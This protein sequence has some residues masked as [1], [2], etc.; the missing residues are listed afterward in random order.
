M[1]STFNL[2]GR[3]L[4]LATLTLFALA[5]GIAYAAIP[6]AG[7]GVYHAC[8]K[9]NGTIRII[10][11]ASQQ[12]KPSAEVEITFN[13]EGPK[14]DQGDPGPQ[15]PAGPPGQDG[16]DGEDGKDGAPFSGTFTS[17]NGQYSISVTDSGIVLASPDSSIR[18]LDNAIR[19][20]SIGTD[21]ARGALATPSSCR[22]VQPSSSRVA[23]P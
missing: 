15:G 7:T 16:E 3:R 21:T 22:A 9:K 23:A 6:D 11:P 17:P 19:V 20:E 10:D 14:G 4:A 13:R 12:C 8:M 18:L 5:G 2:R 1:N